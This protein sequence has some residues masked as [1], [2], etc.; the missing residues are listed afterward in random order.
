[1]PDL[2]DRPL[3]S[4]AQKVL[5]FRRAGGELA[6]QLRRKATEHVAVLQEWLAV[7]LGGADRFG[8]DRFGRADLAAAPMVNRSAFYGIGPAA[9]TPLGRWLDRAR[10]RPSVRDTFAEFEAA[11]ARM[12]AA[13]SLYTIGGRRRED[14]D[15]RL[16]W[17]IRAG[18]IEVVRAGLATGTIRFSW[19]GPVP[20]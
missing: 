7:R 9:D 16:D 14:R 8:G 20:D 19:P 4:F 1:M 5:W 13:P 15:H 17:M 2:M 10:T 11:A 18:G 12:A 3:S 6:E